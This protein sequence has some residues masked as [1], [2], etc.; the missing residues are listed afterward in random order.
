MRWPRDQQ[1]SLTLFSLTTNS[2]DYASRENPN[3][4]SQPQLVLSLLGSP[5]MHLRHRRP[6]H[7]RERHDRPHP[8]HRRRQLQRHP[9]RHRRLFQSRARAPAN[10][11]FGG[12]GT[13]LTVTVTP[14]ANQSGTALITVDRDRFLQP[15]RQRQFHAYGFE[16]PGLGHCLERPRRGRQHLVGQQLTGRRPK[17]RSFWTT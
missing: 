3:P 6:H 7:R 1:L 13:N 16:P 17:C 10:I 9:H 5:P 15:Q 14:A 12:S 2:V 11:V 8:F 4:G